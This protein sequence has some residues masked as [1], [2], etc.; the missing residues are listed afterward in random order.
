MA[1]TPHA[2]DIGKRTAQYIEL[3]DK[4]KRMNDAHKEKMKP[5]VEALDQ[6]NLVLLHHLQTIGVDSAASDAGTVYRKETVRASTADGDA[7]R[8]FII[9]YGAWD[10]VDIKPNA[11]AVQDFVNEN[12][13]VP[14]GVNLTTVV[15]VGVRRK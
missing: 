12:G 6:L 1:K 15:D 8:Q 3:R 7:F 4:I 5:F 11:P 14:P 13:S 2:T 9:Q 10:L